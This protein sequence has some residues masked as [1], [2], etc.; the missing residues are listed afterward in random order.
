MIFIND[1]QETMFNQFGKLIIRLSETEMQKISFQIVSK[2]SRSVL[3]P[4]ACSSVIPPLFP[5]Q[6]VVLK[7]WC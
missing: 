1:N 7:D 3:H 5:F 2:E 6:F 4:P